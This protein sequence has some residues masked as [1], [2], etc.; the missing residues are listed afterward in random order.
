MTHF[1]GTD[2]EAAARH[3]EVFGFT[4][5]RDAFRANALS[6]E[7]DLA[8]G[9]SSWREFASDGDTRAAMG[10]YVPMMCE[11]TPESIALLARFAPL[12]ERFLSRAVLPCRAKGVQYQGAT[13]WHRDT[14]LPVRSIGFLAYLEPLTAADGALCVLPG[15][16]GA[17]FGDALREFAEDAHLRMDRWPSVAL[18]TQPGDVIV[19]DEHLFHASVGGDL[20]RQWRADFI[21][22]PV[23]PNEEAAARDYFGS[24]HAPDW[25]GGYDVD[26]YPSYGAFWRARASQTW[27][28]GLE[29]VGALAAAQAEEAAARIRR[30]TALGSAQDEQ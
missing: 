16:H 6:L 2:N 28:A 25:D 12:A 7:L 3:F 18:T 5:L 27:V 22:V 24:M 30:A 10:R 15:S 21:A 29:R 20:R 17:A 11:H 13:A 9:D 19:M 4:L 23:A 1:N 8:I 14:D 26:R